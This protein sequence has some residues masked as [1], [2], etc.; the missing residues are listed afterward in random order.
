MSL[1][2]EFLNSGELAKLAGVSSDTLRHYERKGVLA[3]P[4]RAGNGYR[5][6]PSA[7]LQRVQ[8]IRRSLGVGFTLDELANILRVR[9]GGGAPCHEVRAL[10]ATKLSHV[11]TQLK[12]LVKL[13]NELRVAVRD[14]DSRLARKALGGRANLLESL[15]NNESNGTRSSRR[16]RSP[17]KPKI[18]KEK[19]S[20]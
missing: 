16:F 2:K 4:R 10:A 20:K 6:Y 15:V 18:K 12:E 9:D 1:E 19:R 5:E 14:W 17:L 7:A 13:R 3:R 11:E 8:L